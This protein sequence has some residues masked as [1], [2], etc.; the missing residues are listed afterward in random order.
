MSEPGERDGIHMCL[1]CGGQVVIDFSMARHPPRSKWL[2]CVDCRKAYRS[3]DL[4][5]LSTAPKPLSN[6][7]G[8]LRRLVERTINGSYTA[9]L[10]ASKK[11]KAMHETDRDY[12]LAEIDRLAAEHAE[13]VKARVE[14]SAMATEYADKLRVLSA[15]F[16]VVRAER[17]WFKAEHAAL[18]LAVSNAAS[19]LRHVNRTLHSDGVLQVVDELVDA[20]PKETT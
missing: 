9:G 16:S 4:A 11:R 17:D 5:A 14:F 8:E 13:T 15:R 20:L 2:S 10:I 19:R 3:E 1:V 12:A 7:P 18:V 6:E